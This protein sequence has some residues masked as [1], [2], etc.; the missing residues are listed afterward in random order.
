L[1][2]AEEIDQICTH[3]QFFRSEQ[4]ERNPEQDFGQIGLLLPV[5]EERLDGSRRLCA[6]NH[7]D[8]KRIEQ[9]H[10]A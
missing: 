10:L 1:D 4:Q 9:T 8:L 7:L 3:K 2:T 6:K 5:L